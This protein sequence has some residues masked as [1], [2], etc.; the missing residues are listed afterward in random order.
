MRI[1]QEM[2]EREWGGGHADMGEEYSLSTQGACS[3]RWAIRLPM[4]LIWIRRQILNASLLTF[5]NV[6]LS[7]IPRLSNTVY[8]GVVR[9]CRLKV[10]L[11][12]DNNWQST[13]FLTEVT[14]CCFIKP[15]FF[16]FFNFPQHVQSWLTSYSKMD[17]FIR[18]R[19]Q[20]QMIHI[21]KRSPILFWGI[22]PYLPSFLFLTSTAR[23]ASSSPL[24]LF[25]S[26]SSAP[27]NVWVT[28]GVLL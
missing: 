14:F 6:M 3:T 17:G 9:Y 21:Y 28:V 24:L 16:F 4:I 18:C 19:A 25:F 10:S 27:K 20:S 8:F 13:I 2:Q 11:F 7:L 22:L 23:L 5:F 15:F 1:R 12:D 26:L